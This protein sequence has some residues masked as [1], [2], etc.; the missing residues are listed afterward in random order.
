MTPRPVAVRFEELGG[1]DAVGVV[2][3]A[4]EVASHRGRLRIERERRLQL[5]QR[6]VDAPLLE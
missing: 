3:R 4:Q 5:D 1:L 2:E 6:F